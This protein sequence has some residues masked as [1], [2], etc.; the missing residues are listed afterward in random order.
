MTT[1][2][3]NEINAMSLKEYAIYLEDLQTYQ[4]KRNFVFET[5]QQI[6]YIKNSFEYDLKEFLK[7][8]ERAI[9]K[10]C[11]I[12]IIDMGYEGELWNPPEP[13]QNKLLSSYLHDIF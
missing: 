8:F 9:K 12:E 11:E 1:L 4:D 10:Q 13:K 7:L 5:K 3:N 2:T 6:R